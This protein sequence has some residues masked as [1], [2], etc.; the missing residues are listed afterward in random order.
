MELGYIGFEVAD[1]E[2][3]SRLC[4]DVIGLMPA[5]ENTDGSMFPDG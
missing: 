2:A 4:T 5:A 3:W 1:V